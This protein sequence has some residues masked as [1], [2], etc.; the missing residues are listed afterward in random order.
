MSNLEFHPSIDPMERIYHLTTKIKVIETYGKQGQKDTGSSF[1][2]AVL[3]PEQNDETTRFFAAWL[4]DTETEHFEC[5]GKLGY[6][7]YGSGRFAVCR[8]NKNYHEPHLFV[9]SK[10][11]ED[12]FIKKDGE[13]VMI[14]VE[15]GTSDATEFHESDS[16]DSDVS[17]Q[18]IQLGGRFSKPRF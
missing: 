3:I 9:M 8:G 14:E 17:V 16:T 11:I 5:L 10:G 6:P 2:I 1:K 12:I 4:P 7:V 18:R 13:K 15:R